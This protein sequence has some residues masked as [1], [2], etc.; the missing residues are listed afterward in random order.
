MSSESLEPREVLEVEPEVPPS[1]DGRPRALVQAKPELGRT[2]FVRPLLLE[3]VVDLA[4]LF[5]AVALVSKVGLFDGELLYLGL[6]PSLA[7]AGELLTGP[8]PAWEP[9]IGLFVVSG[10]SVLE[11]VV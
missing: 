3:L 6:F 11:L 8:R 5:A 9:V 2:V 10:L 4:T 1:E 7:L